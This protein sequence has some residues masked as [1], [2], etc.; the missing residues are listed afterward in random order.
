[1]LDV[2]NLAM[3]AG[4]L[5]TIV[6]A[7]GIIVTPILRAFK[8]V[9]TSL[10]NTSRTILEIKL[11]MENSRRDNKFFYDKIEKHEERLDH[12]KICLTQHDEKLKILMGERRG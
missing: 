11:E 3:W 8:E 1:M 9:N 10:A 4:W 2:G 6:G 7:I 5:V 12:H